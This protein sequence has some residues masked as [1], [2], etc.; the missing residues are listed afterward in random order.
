MHENGSLSIHSENIFPI[1]KKWLYSDQ[2]I[3]IRELVS[4]ASDAIMKLKKLSDMGEANIPEDTEFEIKVLVDAE[5][6]II[7]VIDNGIGMT[8]DEVKQYINQIAFSGAEDFLEKYKDKTDQ[9]Q[10]IG[11]FGLGFYSAFM[12]A[13]QVQ[14]DTLSYQE[15][16][17]PVKWTCE[18]GTEYQMDAGSRKERGTTITLYVSEEGK[19]FLNEYTLRSTL[20][21]YCSFMPVE[22]YFENANQPAPKE[23][24][25]TSEDIEEIIPKPI[26]NPAPLYLKNPNECTE[27]EY[28]NF[29]REVFHD[30]EDPL[31]WIHLNMDYPFKMKG[32]LYF[33][34]L[35]NEFE[36]M[37]GQIKLYCSQV[38]IAD[39][40]KEVIPEFLLLL[41]GVMDCPDFPL[42]VSRSFLQ[43]DG[44]V[45]KISNYISKKVA[46]K[47]KSLYRTEKEQYEKF[48]NDIHP[49]IKYGCLRD[50]K[51]YER[52][53]PF[54]I[55]QTTKGD[56]VTLEEYLERNKEKHE[57]TV[58]YATHE[59]QQSQYINIFKENDLE[60]VLLTSNIDPP[61]I[62]HVEMKESGISFKRVDSDLSD[63]LRIK[64]EG[65]EE[66]Q[67]ETNEN[68][69]KMFKDALEKENLKINVENLKSETVAAMI[70]LSEQS[71][72]MQDM[73]HMFGNLPM[74]MFP[75]EETLV[76]NKRNPLVQ[77]LLQLQDES[78]QADDVKMICEH[79]YDLALL[80]HK[81]LES[82]QMNRFIQRNQEILNRLVK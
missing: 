41:K 20:Q 59:Q 71:R 78:N 35:K 82:D 16:A 32:I 14:I 1:I 49:F 64:E 62:S 21:K 61:F 7:Q 81:P 27:E 60:A 45:T 34:K 23:E 4:N 10:I 63:V 9:D 12:V 6:K 18:G 51:F 70:L 46:D 67:K 33:P 72:R 28:K 66:E 48:W 44:Y 15:G 30:F 50:D 3:F 5:K 26:N 40:I 43:N 74:D 68:I 73:S 76:I 38:F 58:F 52:M 53:N 42:N 19:S 54:V 80:S 2:D 25:K 75:K 39:N 57:K 69:E 47:L 56:Y 17:A 11:H 77:R 65:N 13:D 29:Y 22:V 79:L 24:D 8:H 36:T 31:F 37:E 55:Y